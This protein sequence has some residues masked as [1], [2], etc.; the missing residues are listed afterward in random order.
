MSSFF[1]FVCSKQKGFLKKVTENL[2]LSIFWV[3]LNEKF[4]FP[5][6]M[7]SSAFPLKINRIMDDRDII[8]LSIYFFRRM[9]WKKNVFLYPQKE[10]NHLSLSCIV[11]KVKKKSQIW[12]KVFSPQYPFFQKPPSYI[13]FFLRW[14]KKSGE[15]W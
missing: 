14:A 5:R 2:F 8:I 15:K 6:T 11:S 10:C 3:V 12:K 7:R 1:F 9:I 13:K 4:F